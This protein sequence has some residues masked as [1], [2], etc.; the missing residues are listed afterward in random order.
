MNPSDLL[1]N[2]GSTVSCI[3]SQ[4]AIPAGKIAMQQQ[5]YE[6]VLCMHHPGYFLITVYEAYKFK[7]HGQN[8]NS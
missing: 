1:K 7:T 6:A 3:E 4:L 2:A 8:V 5:T